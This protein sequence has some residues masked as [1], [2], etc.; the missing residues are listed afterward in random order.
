MQSKITRRLNAQDGFTLVELL[1]VLMVLGALA[2]LAMPAFASQKDKSQD[3]CAKSMTR[4]M[5][6]AMEALYMDTYT[7]DDASPTALNE[8]ESQVPA[9]GVAACSGTAP[10]ATGISGSGPA[11]TGDDPG[12]GGGYCVAATSASGRTFVIDRSATGAITRHCSS[13]GGGC[14]DDLTW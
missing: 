7:Y 14:R 2:A 3:T 12:V 6:T 10:V 13:V 8:V 11:C 1:V 5:Q 9:S 4:T